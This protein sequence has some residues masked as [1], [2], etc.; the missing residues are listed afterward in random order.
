MCGI[1]GII[2]NSAKNNASTFSF[3]YL[4]QRIDN[5]EK[6]LQSK[7]KLNY[8]YDLSWKYKND[9]SFLLY[10]HDYKERSYVE[11]ICLKL[12]KFLEK[13]DLKKLSKIN[14]NVA[15]NIEKIKDINW[16]LKNE[17][18]NTYNF[19]LS[20]ID[21]NSN[22]LNNTSIIF[23]KNL[24]TIINSINFLE[25]RG[26]DSLGISINLNFIFKD[27]LNKKDIKDTVY[28]NNNK[29]FN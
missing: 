13:A 19:V 22:H 5:L 21:T 17:L 3:Y 26:R 27:T 7:R 14:T 18:N 23:Y 1:S 24:S 20:F 9:E 28:I 15:N 29:K 10:F 16:F 11:K 8:L 4:L 12:E 6:I 25:M 2:F